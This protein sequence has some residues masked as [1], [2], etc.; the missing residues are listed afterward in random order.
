MIEK[1]ILDALSRFSLLKSGDSVTVALSGGAD[2]IAL[3]Y[4]LHRLTP[5]LNIKL[6]AAHL[7]HLIRGE[8]A[9]RDEEFVKHFCKKLNIP[10]ISERA[11]VPAAAKAD[12]LSLETAARNVRYEF[13]NRVSEGVI[14][15]AHTASDNLETLILNLTRGAS[16]QG[17]GGIPI[18]R[19]NI[20]RPLLFCTREEIEQYCARHFLPFVTDSTNLSDD[21]TR[22]KIRHSIVP[23]LKEINP[24]AE[25]AALR[26]SLSIREAAGFIDTTAQEYLNNNLRENAL[27]LTDFNTLESGLA[28]RI[29][30]LYVGKIYPAISLE[31]CHIDAALKVALQ[32][33]KTEIPMGVY[34]KRVKNSLHLIAVNEALPEF[35][36]KITCEDK[37]INNLL[38]NNSLDCDKIVGK[39]VVRTRQSGD[40]IRLLNRGCT[41]SLTKLYNEIPIPEIERDILPVISDDLGVV[42][43]YGVGVAHRCAVS[44]NTEKY[45]YIDV[46]MK[47]N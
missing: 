4:A 6:S 22:N 46:N 3:L 42:W 28:K 35:S 15:T 33:G 37:K 47:G 25:N 24:K 39:L 29:I 45:Y 1:K 5:Q 18:K 38:L 21:Y 43:I 30:T 12:S 26:A 34:C 19:D 20:I 7:N 36:V 44:S 16:L 27:D 11:D 17:L 32:G 10:L 14:A 13:L 31:A 40:K 9:F 23:V 8:E 41:K 2:S